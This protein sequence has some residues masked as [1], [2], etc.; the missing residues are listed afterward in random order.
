MSQFRA[1]STDRVLF[2]PVATPAV[3]HVPSAFPVGDDAPAWKPAGQLL[4]AGDA[5]VE[6][7]S[8]QSIVPI[9]PVGGRIGPP[10]GVRLTDGR[11]VHAVQFYPDSTAPSDHDNALLNADII[12]SALRAVDT[13]ALGEWADRLRL[14]GLW[15]DRWTGPDLLGQ[16]HAALRRPVDRLV[17]NLLDSD[18]WL[19]LN[20][21][22][23]AAWPTEVAVGVGL[24]ARLSG[25]EQSWAL[26]DQADP[27][28]RHA[29]VREAAALYAS[30]LRMAPIEND[31]PQPDPTL[32]VFATTRRRLKPGRLPTDQGVLLVDAVGAAA[33]GRLL[34]EASAA[35][36]LPV[37]VYD[38]PRNVLRCLE[39]L[40]GTPVSAVL[41]E[42]GVPEAVRE[43]Y[44]GSPLRQLRVEGDDVFAGGGESTLFAAPPQPRPTPDPCVRCGWCVEG[45]PTRCRPA[46]L[47]EAAQRDD[48]DLAKA[49][50][51][52]AC[53]E[54]GLCTYVCPS[55]LPLLEGIRILRSSAR[56]Y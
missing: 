21:L 16:L 54:C 20:G 8:A 12:Q 2:Q 24:L 30:D 55:R 34:I 15:A 40:P 51:L 14:H 35:T 4:S 5:L 53:I 31:Y 50:G 18:P 7:P 28:T 38:Q 10:C 44:A 32:V 52:D 56:S 13:T 42:V 9:A 46:S 1:M 49:A 36:T 11:Q 47:L 17:L 22:A 6:N 26:V 37:V 29:E 41:E 39:V 33:V 19:S 43:I 25:A 3:L 48:L 23:V 27:P 45:C